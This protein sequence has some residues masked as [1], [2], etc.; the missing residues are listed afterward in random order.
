MNAIETNLPL[1]QGEI[2]IRIFPLKRPSVLRLA[3]PAV[4]E[5]P[6]LRKAITPRLLTKVAIDMTIVASLILTRAALFR[7]PPN[8]CFAMKTSTQFAGQV[9][10]PVKARLSPHVTFNSLIKPAEAV[11]KVG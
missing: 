4:L 6:G 11:P 1:P 10:Y 9:R 7:R 2:Q 8:G 5:M 3:G